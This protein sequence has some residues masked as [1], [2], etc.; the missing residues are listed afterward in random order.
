ER[1]IA[2]LRSLKTVDRSAADREIQKTRD[3]LRAQEE[4]LHTPLEE[5]K[6]D[7]GKPPKTVKPGDT[8]KIVSL[9]QKATVLAAPDAKGE[10][11]LQAG[12]M[13]MS[14]R[15]D[16]LRLI[17]E[18]A[19]N[20]AEVKLSQNL[21]RAVGLELDIRGM[22]VDDAIPVVDRYLDDAAMAGLTE[23][24]IIHGKGTGALRAGIQAHLKRHPRSKGFR[25][26]NYGEGDAGV[27][28]VTLR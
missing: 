23:V 27:T 14:L 9:D 26:G 18:Q 16:D 1:L 6:I 21:S 24:G 19:R 13:K 5:Q 11:L 10:V 28:F 4:A 12:I 17:E 7:T 25:I 15:L 20:K 2:E 3:A 22:M 8:V